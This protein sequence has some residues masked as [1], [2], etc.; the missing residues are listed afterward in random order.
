MK[1]LRQAYLTSRLIPLTWIPSEY[2]DTGLFIGKV[3]N[4]GNE[5]QQYNQEVEKWQIFMFGVTICLEGEMCSH[6]AFSEM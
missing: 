1:V 2:K 4:F 3:S 6:V 5:L